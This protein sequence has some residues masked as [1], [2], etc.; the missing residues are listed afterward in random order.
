MKLMITTILLGLVPIAALGAREPFACN[1]LALTKTERATHQKLSRALFAAVQE[2]REL[3]NGY[4]FRLPAASLVKAAQ[5]VALEGRCCP[6]F[7]FQ[8]DVAKNEGPVWLRVTGS[9]GIKPFIRAEFQ[10]DS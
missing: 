1:M 10:L 8:V 3:P 2:R 9:E 4:A 6:F 7:T 5:W